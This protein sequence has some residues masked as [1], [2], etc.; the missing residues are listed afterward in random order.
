[1]T[2]RTEHLQWCKTRALDYL[3]P[4]PYFSMDYAIASMV[5]DLGKHEETKHHLEFTVPL[6]FE[7]RMAGKL[8]TPAELKHF[9]EGFN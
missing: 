2:T 4:G 3:K 6:M 1:M 5:S 8:N 7:L 9:I